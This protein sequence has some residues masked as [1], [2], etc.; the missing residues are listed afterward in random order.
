MTHKG[1]VITIASNKGGVGKTTTATCIAH[2]L[3][4]SGNKVLFV[5]TDPQGN[6]SERF[7]LGADEHFRKN[8]LGALILDRLRDEDDA[9]HNPISYYINSLSTFPNIDVIT[10]DIRLDSVY[11]QMNT[12]AFSALTMFKSIVQ[13]IKEQDMYDYIIIDTRPALTTEVG[14]IFACSEHILLPLQAANDSIEG[15]IATM[16]FIAKAR[17]MNPDINII[18]LFFNMI[19]DRTRAFQKLL[20]EVSNGLQDK[21]CSTVVPRSQDVVNAENDHKIV[22]S[23]YPSCKASKAFVKL[24]DELLERLESEEK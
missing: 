3:S 16:K 13:E 21:I 5:D 12:H 1:T 15:A 17:P 2:L 10:S 19:V 18:G 22:T 8:Y 24:L 23:K 4:N 9:I 20:G 11:A 6:A 7:G 14:S